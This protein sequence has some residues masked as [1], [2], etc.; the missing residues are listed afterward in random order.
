MK[1]FLFG[2][3]LISY[4]VS[5]LQEVFP[6]GGRGQYALNYW[7]ARAKCASLG[8]SLASIQ[9]LDQ[10]RLNGLSHCSCG[11]L[12]EK[13]AGY[14]MNETKAGCGNRPGVH[15]CNWRET[16]DAF[17]YMDTAIANCSSPLGVET[18]EITD[19]QMTASSVYHSFWNERWNPHL[20]RLHKEGVINAWM[21]HHDG[22]NQYL[23]IDMGS[24]MAVTGIVTQGARR[25]L[26][27][28]FVTSF[29]VAHSKDGEF[30]RTYTEDNVE[31]IF[32]GNFDND[33]PVRN[34][35]KNPILARYIKF[36]PMT[37]QKHIT[38]R[39]ELYGCDI[40]DYNMELERKRAVRVT[41]MN[42]FGERIPR[43]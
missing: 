15:L 4:A 9:E 35:F 20:A 6:V 32:A 41:A 24:A 38:L 8:A 21:P 36:K 19:G 40:E 16:W 29:K 43:Q 11:W 34:S 17:C 31:K 39:M 26:A 5:S 18:G 25:Y 27:N 33:T 7:Q 30:W 14:P 13:K 1:I 3:L 22:R 37:Y 23:E 2:I 28:Q 10:A 42:G 12:L